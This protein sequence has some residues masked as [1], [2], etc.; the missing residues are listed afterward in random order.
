MSLGSRKS[1]AVSGILK[2][3]DAGSTVVISGTA[4]CCNVM[5][6]PLE[7]KFHQPV[8]STCLLIFH[9]LWLLCVSLA[10]SIRSR[11]VGSLPWP[12]CGG[13]DPH[14]VLSAMG[15][16]P[17]N[18]VQHDRYWRRF[19]QFEGRPRAG[20][21]RSREAEPSSRPGAREAPQSGRGRPGR[22]GRRRAA[23]NSG[24]ARRAGI[25]TGRSGSRP[26]ARTT[27][28]AGERCTGIS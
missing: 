10:D 11:P 6:S 5:A 28:P 13:P 17:H 7:M 12:G 14:S 27:V 25:G 16:S 1:V 18:S 15:P 9:D 22:R 19:I 26:A 24:P 3:R 4:A 21:P 20:S 23:Y 8:R 2:L